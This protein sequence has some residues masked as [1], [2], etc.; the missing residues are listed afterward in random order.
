MTCWRQNECNDLDVESDCLYILA[1]R[2]LSIL[3]P[4]QICRRKES[5]N[6][7]VGESKKMN[8]ENH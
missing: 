2:S 7:T 5:N 8:V 3:R 4:E 6:S 1:P